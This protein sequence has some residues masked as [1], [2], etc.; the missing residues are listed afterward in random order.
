MTESYLIDLL[1]QESDRLNYQ[2]CD[3]KDKFDTGICAWK[4][5]NSQNHFNPHV[6]VSKFRIRT[7]RCQ[8]SLSRSNSSQSHLSTLSS[9]NSRNASPARESEKVSKVRKNS[10]NFCAGLAEPPFMCQNFNDIRIMKP[11]KPRKARK[12]IKVFKLPN[13]SQENDE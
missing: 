9:G 12:P 1:S 4:D 11:P 3:E 6:E 8:G 2:N 13:V 7:V 10:T 5:V